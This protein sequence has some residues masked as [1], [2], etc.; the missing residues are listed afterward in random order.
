[1]K[2]NSLNISGIFRDTIISSIE[3]PS[4]KGVTTENFIE[5]K[6]RWELYGKQIYEK[7]KESGRN[8]TPTTLKAAI[9]NTNLRIF[10]AAGRINASSLEKI[11]ESRVNESIQKRC[12]KKKE[13]ENSSLINE[14]V[15]KRSMRMSILVAEDRV[16]SLHRSY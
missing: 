12:Q 14:S 7:S 4:L 11:K 1:M 3:G 10:L 13:K 9:N 5:L 6:K 16:R 2:N 15:L 8:N